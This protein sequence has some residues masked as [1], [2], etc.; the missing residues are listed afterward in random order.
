MNGF[1]L[2]ACRGRAEGER[3]AEVNGGVGRRL[4]LGCHMSSCCCD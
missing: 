1:G 2:R 4:E 3:G